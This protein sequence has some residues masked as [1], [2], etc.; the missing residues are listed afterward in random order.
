MPELLAL[1]LW[2]LLLAFVLVA[3]GVAAVWFTLRRMRK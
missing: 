1:T 3:A 2:G